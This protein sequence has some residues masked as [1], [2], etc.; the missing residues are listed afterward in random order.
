MMLAGV[1]KKLGRIDEA[2]AQWRI[3]ANLEAMYPSYEE[4]IEGAKSE[5]KSRGLAF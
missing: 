4:P 5:L 3:V 1:L 2:I